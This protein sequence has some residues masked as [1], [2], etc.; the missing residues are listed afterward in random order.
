MKRKF[1]TGDRVI[2]N[3]NHESFVLDYYT[4]ETVCVRIWSQQRHVGDTVVHEDELTLQLTG[5]SNE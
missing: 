2:C 3:G 5:V 4:D 1:K